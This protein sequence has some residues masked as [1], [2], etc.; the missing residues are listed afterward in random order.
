MNLLIL[1]SLAW[2]L[3]GFPPPPPAAQ[4]KTSSII[5]QDLTGSDRGKRLAAFSRYAANGDPA[6]A[7]Q[8]IEDA[9]ASDDWLLQA[10]VVRDAFSKLGS[11]P[12]ALSISPDFPRADPTAIGSGRYVFTINRL[13]PNS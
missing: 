10:A 6:V 8:A 3:V 4:T 5:R 1:L 7:K 11:L 12:V 2:A 13:T 9:M